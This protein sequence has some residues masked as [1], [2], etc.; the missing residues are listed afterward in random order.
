[1]PLSMRSFMNTTCPREAA[2]IGNLVPQIAYGYPNSFLEAE[3]AAAGPPMVSI[4]PSGLKVA[5]AVD[6]TVRARRADGSLATVCNVAV[7]V[8]VFGS[9][10]M[11]D[12][13]IKVAVTQIQANVTSITNSTVGTINNGDL[14]ATLE[15]LAKQYLKTEKTEKAFRI[16]VSKSVQLKNGQS[17]MLNRCVVFTGDIEMST[18]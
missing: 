1:M 2:C 4:S 12:A 14:S 9:I 11:K 18:P 10:S 6:Q 15:A 16:P 5:I 3:L 17:Y 7:N 13:E 8:T